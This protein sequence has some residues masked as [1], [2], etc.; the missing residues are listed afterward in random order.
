MKSPPQ[1]VPDLSSRQSSLPVCAFAELST[2]LVHSIISLGAAG[3]GSSIDLPQCPRSGAA[4][5]PNA[6]FLYAAP[7]RIVLKYTSFGL[8]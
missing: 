6:R 8:L 3:E 4:Y 7:P 5:W 2:A 1:V